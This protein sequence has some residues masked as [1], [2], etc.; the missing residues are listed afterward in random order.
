MVEIVK[1]TTEQREALNKLWWVYGNG[2][3]KSTMGNHKFIQWILE[4]GEY[5]PEPLYF[6]RVEGGRMTGECRMAVDTVLGRV[7]PD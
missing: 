4:H 3:E 7:I 1:L 2:G 6:S 5:N